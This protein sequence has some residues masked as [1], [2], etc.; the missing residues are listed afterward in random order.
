MKTTAKIFIL[1]IV[2]TFILTL[3]CNAQSNIT[4]QMRCDLYLSEKHEDTYASSFVM[5]INRICVLKGETPPFNTNIADVQSL[6]YNSTG[7]KESFSYNG[8]KIK[9]Q[10]N[11]P[12]NTVLKNL[13]DKHPEGVIL[14]NSKGCV[15]VTSYDEEAGEFMCFDTHPSSPLGKMPLS[16]TSITSP[17]KATTIYTY[18]LTNL[19]GEVVFKIPLNEDTA[20]IIYHDGAT[21]IYDVQTETVSK[22]FYLSD[23]APQ[24]NGM[25]FVGWADNATSNTVSY[26]PMGIYTLHGD[27]NL[28]AVYEKEETQHR[29]QTYTVNYYSNEELIHTQT[30]DGTGFTTFTPDMPIPKKNGY[31]FMGWR[32]SFY[33]EN[34][35]YPMN[36]PFKLCSDMNFYAVWQKNGSYSITYSAIHATQVPY[37]QLTDNETAIVSPITPKK[38]G[39]VFNGWYTSNGKVLKP[40][41]EFLLTD[42]LMLYA[43]FEKGN[44]NILL[45]A[46]KESFNISE[47]VL[48]SFEKASVSNAKYTVNIINLKDGSTTQ[49][50]SEGEFKI[51][52]PQGQYTAYV[53]ADYTYGTLTSNKVNF[54]VWSQ[55][56]DEKVDVYADGKA[57]TFDTPPLVQNGVTLVPLRAIISEFG[58]QLF[59]NEKTETVTA[60]SGINVLKFTVGKGVYY[61]N[62]EQKAVKI[63][64]QIIDGRVYIPLRALAEGFDYNVYWQNDTQN[65]YI[66]SAA[67]GFVGENAYY[68]N[69]GNYNLA[70]NDIWIISRVNENPNLYEIRSFYDG[71]YLAVENRCVGENAKV[72]TL[73]AGA[74]LSALWL[75]EKHSDGFYIRN[76]ED[77]T[78]YLNISSGNPLLNTNKHSFKILPLM[79]F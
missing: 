63:P 19:K 73:H 55:K 48:L 56:A 25:R 8:V 64:P 60:V 7:L 14:G 22:Y 57:I 18:S 2:L 5:L 4:N 40:L 6:I 69:D 72:T 41:Q 58:A 50:S 24:K 15:L 61:K 62:G 74:Y 27:I 39:Y 9:K 71:T 49:H 11:K 38:D 43:L 32:A 30:V 20:N 23:T 65:I 3:A 13:L 16:K 37:R 45:K 34:L 76:A 68:I 10:A 67:Y 42:N 17:L 75:I 51:N 29:K 54:M 35:L 31:K 33:G 70:D 21:A 26:V 47:Q 66:Y 53:R 28:Y 77:E 79:Q 78:L 59:W 44:S 46:E 36:E 12:D 1:G 52:L